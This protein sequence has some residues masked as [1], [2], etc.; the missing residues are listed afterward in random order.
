MDEIDQLKKAKNNA[1]AA[2]LA[3][4]KA[5]K[6]D[7]LVSNT[8][9]HFSMLTLAVV[10]GNTLETCL[11]DY[12]KREKLDGRIYTTQRKVKV[13]AHRQISLHIPPPSLMIHLKRFDNSRSKINKPISFPKVL[14]ML[15]YCSPNSDV[16]EAK[17]DLC[18]VT[19]HIGGSLNY[20]HYVAYVKGKND[21]W[22]LCD[23]DSVRQVGENEVLK[24]QS[25]ILYYSMRES[26]FKKLI[27][28]TP[29]L[30]PAATPNGAV[31]GFSLGA[32]SSSS[33]SKKPSE[34]GGV[35]LSEADIQRALKA[36]K[37]KMLLKAEEAERQEER[38]R[39]KAARIQKDKQTRAELPTDS[40]TDEDNAAPVT[41]TANVTKKQSAPA[42][43]P[44]SLPSTKPQASASEQQ[45]IG[46]K[47][48]AAIKARAESQMNVYNN[49]SDEDDEVGGDDAEEDDEADSDDSGEEYEEDEGSASEDDNIAPQTKKKALPAPRL[50]PKFA[51]IISAITLNS[52]KA[53]PASK[54]L[55]SP[56]SKALPA[57]PTSSGVPST[58]VI[59]PKKTSTVSKGPLPN[60]LSK[61]AGLMGVIR[62]Q[63]IIKDE[64]AA[65]ERA[66]AE[67]E[68]EDVEPAK[69]AP[70]RA[71]VFAPQTKIKTGE[72]LRRMRIKRVVD[73]D[74]EEEESSNNK[75]HMVSEEAEE[76][77]P[78]SREAYQRALNGENE[79][80]STSGAT[81]DR[82]RHQGVFKKHLRDEEWAQEFDRGKLKKVRTEHRQHE[83]D[84]F[85]KPNSF[86]VAQNQKTR[87]EFVP[88][89]RPSEEEK[90]TMRFEARGGRG[91]GRGGGF[92]RGRGGDRGGF[93]SGG[94]G[95]QVGWGNQESGSFNGGVGQRPNGSRRISFDN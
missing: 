85:C 66:A 95:G 3:M 21:L 77:V 48:A 4:D 5:L 42:M 13:I 47:A 79:D 61:F 90:R 62:Q 70:I 6:S 58:Q 34:D 23:D 26:S 73:E 55:P 63:Q 30:G 9:E 67:A 88:K 8:Y 60:S 75:N 19:V 2:D 25:L 50:S 51:P 89:Y 31:E 49:D 14:D 65:E 91:G 36:A 92:E 12:F 1:A 43:A 7:K 54:A 46:K 69:N 39:L 35:E 57:P 87:G 76:T 68:E 11:K 78:F 37:E 28:P 94:R 18:A 17:Y 33:A 83:D 71:N 82:R 20:G 38:A 10:A 80:G 22:Y 24:A 86:Q 59:V 16:K 53:S 64:D 81:I 41:S 45:I 40:D 15:P 52:K 84:K 93:S 27:T 44:L 56:V 32:S 29:L 74:D 72:E